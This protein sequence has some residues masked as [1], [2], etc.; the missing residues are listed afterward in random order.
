M[1]AENQEMEK[2][3]EQIVESRLVTPWHEIT[4]SVFS[5]PVTTSIEIPQPLLPPQQ[6]CDLSN[7]EG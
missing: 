5:A 4:P 7:E 1:L 6:V 2:K 3:E